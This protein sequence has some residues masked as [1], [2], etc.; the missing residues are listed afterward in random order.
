MYRPAYPR[1]QLSLRAVDFPHGPET[2]CLPGGDGDDQ[3]R[4]RPA[5]DHGG[6]GPH[7]P[8]GEYRLEGADLIRG[9]DENLIHARHA[10]EKVGG[11]QRLNERPPNDHRDVV[12]RGAEHQQ[13]GGHEEARRQ[14][15]A[16]DADAEEGDRDEQRHTGATERRTVGD[17]DSY[18]HGA[19]GRRG[20]QQAETLGTGPEHSGENRQE[21]G[22]AAE[23]YGEEVERHRAEDDGLL[24]E[25][26]QADLQAL[27]NRD[28]AHFRR[29][30]LDVGNED[31]GDESDREHRR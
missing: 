29:A 6:N 19:D 10:T 14:S 31:D 2:R 21:R 18:H 1:R 4:H 24:P 22:R 5:E 16:D 9:A 13:H 11:G 20:A 23:E 30:G 12:G 25:E 3:Q 15:E 27:A 7:Q 28:L 8:R 17:P 26:A